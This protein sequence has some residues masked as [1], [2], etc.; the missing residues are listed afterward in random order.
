MGKESPFPPGS[1][2]VDTRVP[3]QILP[4]SEDETRRSRKKVKGKRTS[5]KSNAAGGRWSIEEDERLRQG[6][7]TSGPKVKGKREGSAAAA[8]AA[9]SLPLPP[10]CTQLACA[11][12]AGNTIITMG[13][14]VQGWEG[15]SL[16]RVKIK[17]KREGSAAGSLPGRGWERMGGGVIETRQGRSLRG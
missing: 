17:G 1:A 10:K 6:V 14:D 5:G 4:D 8:A 2:V 3:V 15:V 12:R 7:T 11:L 9:G 16:K 13:R